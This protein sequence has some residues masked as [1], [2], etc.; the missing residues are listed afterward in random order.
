MTPDARENRRS[1]PRATLLQPHPY[2]VKIIVTTWSLL[3]PDIFISRL[4]IVS[5]RQRARHRLT[6]RIKALI[7]SL[8]TVEKRVREIDR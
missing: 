3:R 1:A 7:D 4:S 6:V 2:G 8:S 5:P